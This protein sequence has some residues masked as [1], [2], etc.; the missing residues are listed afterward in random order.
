MLQ[1]K[2]REYSSRLNKL[3]S[4]KAEMERA[5]AELKA[6][7]VDHSKQKK[8]LGYDLNFKSLA[9]FGDIGLN[10]FLKAE[11]EKPNKRSANI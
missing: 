8:E 3:I 5:G 11:L 10:N 7:G 9:D 2:I 6:L 1:S 4:S